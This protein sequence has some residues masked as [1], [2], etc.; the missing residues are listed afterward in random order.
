MDF[1]SLKTRPISENTN[2]LLYFLL[3]NLVERTQ[4]VVIKNL[5]ILRRLKLI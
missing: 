4:N 5:N 1:I 3:F 2:A